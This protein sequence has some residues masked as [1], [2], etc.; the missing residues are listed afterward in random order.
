MTHIQNPRAKDWNEHLKCA[1][2]FRSERRG[3]GECEAL[4]LLVNASVQLGLFSSPVPLWP[5][6]GTG[7]VMSH[8]VPHTAENT[9]QHQWPVLA[10]PLWC[11][12]PLSASRVPSHGDAQTCTSLTKWWKES[13]ETALISK[14]LKDSLSLENLE[15]KE[16]ERLCGFWAEKETK[17]RTRYHRCTWN[18]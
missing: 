5:R 9:T 6:A 3:W 15:L 14:I 2:W 10:L 13:S 11:H 1:E 7:C 17:H 12:S 16:L 18:T 8:S 4:Q